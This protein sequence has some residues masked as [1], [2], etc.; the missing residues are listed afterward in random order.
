MTDTKTVDTTKIKPSRKL[1]K[2]DPEGLTQDNLTPATAVAASGAFI[3]PEIVDRID[4]DHPA[5]DN[6]PRAGQSVDA[7]LID[8][9]DP[10]LDSAEAVE[11]N[12]GDQGK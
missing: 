3:E 6:N 12:L 10:N 11:K 4:V 2:S 9:N 1:G 8:F 5:V 7:N